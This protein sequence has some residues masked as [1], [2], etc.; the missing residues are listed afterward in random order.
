MTNETEKS[1]LCSKVGEKRK[2]KKIRRRVAFDLSI[3]CAT[4]SQHKLTLIYSRVLKKRKP[5]RFRKCV[6]LLFS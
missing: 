5:F 4:S 2:K 1:A 3:Q 6:E